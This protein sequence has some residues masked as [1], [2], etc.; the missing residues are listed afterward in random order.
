MRSTSL[1]ATVLVFSL[2]ILPARAADEGAF[3]VR[4]ATVHTVSDGTVEN[5]VLVVEN[6]KVKEIR[7]DGSVPGGFRV[8]EAEGKVVT[9]GFVDAGA[10]LGLDANDRRGASAELDV[11]DAFDRYRE[12]DIASI[13]AT[14]TTAV[15]IDPGPP[16]P[17]AGLGA[18]LRLVPGGADL[19]AMT[20]RREAFERGALGL[21]QGSRTTSLQRL[22]DYYSMQRTLV[23]TKEY[24][25]QWEKYKEDLAEYEK[26]KK[27][28][29]EKKKN[30]PKGEG[31]AET[32][33][34]PKPAETEGAG[35][36]RRG[37]RGGRGGGPPPG[38]ERRGG[39]R[40][41]PGG[42]GEGSER[43]AAERSSEGDKDGPPKKPDKPRTDPAREA[44][45][46]VV[47]GERP[48]FLEAHLASDIRNALRLVDEFGVRLVLLGA[49]E[50]VP[51]A[52]E[53]RSRGVAVI[54]G[55]V[56]LPGRRDLARDEHDPALAARLH[57]AKVPVAISSGGVAALGSRYLNL[58]AAAAAS[59]GLPGDAALA[60]ITLR[61]AEALEVA[62]R[63][64]AL[65]P[66]RDA[67]FLIWDRH[68]TEDARARL[69][70]V[71][72]GGVRIDEDELRRR[73]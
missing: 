72:V 26:K 66:G 69:E 25:E 9:P 30:A 55:P 14:G 18:V 57:A 39:F 31:A 47:K 49:T 73:G 23:S 13:R 50:A 21:V 37:G 45:I 68:P 62:D 38:G 54:V 5:A 3:A 24:I 19:A 56:V 33:E 17:F 67:D 22:E 4:G 1:L 51:L 10:I 48:L 58:A 6:G 12:D 8:I 40:R 65:A 20:L 71:Y 64:G 16:G 34:P 11:L 60:S 2:G 46:G 44:L 53:I 36:E 63:I 32:K 28:W 70:A 35:E 15:A 7:A 27:E 59:F 41:P 29:D 61:P 43:P 42:G 52:D